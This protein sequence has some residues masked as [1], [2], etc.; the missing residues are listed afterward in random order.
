[1]GRH[2]IRTNARTPPSG[3]RSRNAVSGPSKRPPS[4]AVMSTPASTISARTSDAAKPTGCTA[5]D[6]SAYRPDEETNKQGG[7]M[8]H[9]DASSVSAITAAPAASTAP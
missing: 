4:D 2:G 8:P 5:P 6:R 1:M 7:S 3:R 9:S